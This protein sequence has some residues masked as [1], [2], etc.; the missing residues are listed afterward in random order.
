MSTRFDAKMLIGGKWLSGQDTYQTRDPY[1]DEPVTTVHTGNRHDVDRAVQAAVA[2]QCAWIDL[3]TYRRVE[4]LRRAADLLMDEADATA[5]AICLETGKPIRSCR[6]EVLRTAETLRFSANAL[7]ALSGQTVPVDESRRGTGR[8]AF[9]MRVPYGVV[10]GIVPF[11]SP[12][13]LAA[14][15]VG[16]ALA[17][18]NAIVLKP[19][20]QTPWCTVR[21]VQALMDAGAP[22]GAV[23]LVF[24][25]AE[26][27]TALVSHPLVRLVSFT[28]GTRTAA[29]IAE[30]AGVKKLLMELGGDGPNIVWR[31]ADLPL[32]ARDLARNA[33]SYAGQS[34]IG[35]QRIFVH[36]EV[37]DKFQPLIV[38]AT[39]DLVMGNPQ[40]EHVDLGPM[41]SAEAAERVK[42]WIDE[43]LADGATLLTG[44]T[45][46]GKFVAPTLLTDVT[47][48]M[49]VVCEEVFGPVAS[50]IPVEDLDGA[51][52]EINASNFGLQAGVFTE[53]YRVALQFARRL[54]VG[55]VL[56]NS[57]S[58]TRVDQQPY[59]GTKS[60][61]IGREGPMYATEEMSQ[62][63]FVGFNL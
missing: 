5:L 9:T 54:D 46:D 17:A 61:G 51:V 15:K 12:M 43:A 60:S 56:I 34:C 10:A 41:N 8:V 18:G 37:W 21:L 55:G 30:A 33:F 14:H 23:N 22:D 20:P 35:V 40:E 58:N 6:D 59:G 44:G 38:E 16:P 36:R 19:H 27:G 1:T 4:V 25:D 50:M 45:R 28:G 52:R 63:R 13:N 62:L 42:S 49:K 47:R 3:P 32:A 11:N 2:G 31:D 39:R 26:V 48:E 24:G 7:T 57:T 29:K 53:S